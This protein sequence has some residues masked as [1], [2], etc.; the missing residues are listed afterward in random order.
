MKTLKKKIRELCRSIM[1][2]IKWFPIIWKDRDWDHYYLLTIMQFKID[3]TEKY[4]SKANRHDD[5]PQISRNLK[6]CSSL[7]DKIK[8]G[9]YEVEY[10]DYYKQEIDFIEDK[11]VFNVLEDNLDK[12]IDKNKL[13]VSKL[14]NTNENL[15]SKENLL[16]AMR[17]GTYKHEHAK[18]LL[19]NIMYDNIEQWWD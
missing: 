5:V 19:F 9:Y 1:H 2:L 15:K 6:L 7:I 10:Q 18:R 8:S 17:V 3:N 14:L 13:I 4:I 16:L 11:L 12:Y